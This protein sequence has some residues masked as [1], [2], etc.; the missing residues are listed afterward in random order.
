MNFKLTALKVTISILIGFLI[1][2]SYEFTQLFGG[3]FMFGEFLLYWLIIALI[4]FIIW[5]L[6][7]E[8][9]RKH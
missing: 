8:G 3:V 1:A 4:I 6:S 9:D 5:S 2:F 7:Q